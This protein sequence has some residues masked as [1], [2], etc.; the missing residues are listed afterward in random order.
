ME[1]YLD[2]SHLEL[3]A[4]VRRFGLEKVAPVARELD[5]TGSFPGGM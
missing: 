3:Q 4:A 2:E 1:P 5:E